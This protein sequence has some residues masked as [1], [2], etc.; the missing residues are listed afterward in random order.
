MEKKN[1]N[2]GKQEATKKDPDL[3]VFYTRPERSC[4]ASSKQRKNKSNAWRPNPNDHRPYGT[5]PTKDDYRQADEDNKKITKDR[6]MDARQD[7]NRK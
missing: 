1:E 4:S 7:K 6:F 2:E 5:R 3:N